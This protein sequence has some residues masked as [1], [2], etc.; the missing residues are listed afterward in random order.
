MNPGGFV[1]ARQTTAAVLSLWFAAGCASPPP[2]FEEAAPADELYA[3]G[4]ENLE[5]RRFLRFIADGDAVSRP[6]VFAIQS[7]C[8]ARDLDPDMPVWGDRMGDLRA[9]GEQRHVHRRVLMDPDRP[10]N[11]TG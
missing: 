10:A 5:G 3:E 9:G 2:T 11:T 4:L 6:E 7:Q 1:T 8:T